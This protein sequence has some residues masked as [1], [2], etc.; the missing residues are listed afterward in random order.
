MQEVQEYRRKG[1]KGNGERGTEICRDNVI[2]S[3]SKD[4]DEKLR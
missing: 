1:E 2:L 3:L 4:I